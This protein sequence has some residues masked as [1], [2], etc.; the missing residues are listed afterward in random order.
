MSA[1]SRKRPAEP[2]SAKKVK[3]RSEASQHIRNRIVRGSGLRNLRTDNCSIYGDNNHTVG[4]FNLLVGRNNT[5]E[6]T[7]NTFSVPAD[8]PVPPPPQPAPPQ[9]VSASQAT[10]VRISLNDLLCRFADTLWNQPGPDMSAAQ[11]ARPVD[12]AADAADAVHWL[13]S[14]LDL[15]GESTLT[16]NEALQCIVCLEHQKDVLFRP[17][18]HAVCC[19]DCTRILA[20]QN[21]QAMSVFKCPKCRAPIESMAIFYI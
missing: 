20:Q 17:C 16:D 15:P 9:P 19:R 1:P 11:P 5:A 8:P 6:G 14:A 3:P 2:T 10:V 13:P 4:N 12:M 21:I 18:R 7:G